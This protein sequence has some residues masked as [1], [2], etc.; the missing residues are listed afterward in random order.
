[1]RYP[2]AGV[3]AATFLLCPLPGHAQMVGPTPQPQ[4]VPVTLEQ[5]D[6]VTPEQWAIHGQATNVWQLQPAF[7]SPYQG[8]QSLSPAANGRETVDVTLYLGFRPWRGAEIWINPEIDLQSRPEL[9]VLP[10]GTSVLSPNNRS[11][12]R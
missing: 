9:S 4:G 2:S 10:N 6:Q 3:L 7:R 12:W 1:M 8:P 11:G 5:A